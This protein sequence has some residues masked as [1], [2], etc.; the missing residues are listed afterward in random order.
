[1]IVKCAQASVLR[2]A[3]PSML[4]ALYCREEMASGDFAEL[5]KRKPHVG[6]LP[7][8]LDDLGPPKAENSQAAE[9]HKPPQGTKA[10]QPPCEPEAEEDQQEPQPESTFNE[11][12][13][14]KL[15]A[16]CKT[17]EEAKQLGDDLM[18]TTNPTDDQ[19]AAIGGMEM[20]ALQRIEQSAK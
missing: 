7:R 4:S 5:I 19:K 13:A 2:T 9:P 12:Q 16:A 15:F 8:T 11:K 3:F 6:T 10:E 1:M 18:A 17:K 14:E 20:E